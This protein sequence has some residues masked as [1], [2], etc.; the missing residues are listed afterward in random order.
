MARFVKAG[1][2]WID[3]SEIW[4]IEPVKYGGAGRI[5]RVRYGQDHTAHEDSESPELA[6]DRCEAIKDACEEHDADSQLG[7]ARLVREELYAELR[8]LFHAEWRR[9][10]GDD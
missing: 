9:A 6:A 7:E 1:D 3:C 2:T 10:K 5:I 8:R 4:S